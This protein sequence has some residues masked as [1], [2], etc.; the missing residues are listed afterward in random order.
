MDAAMEYVLSQ[1][2]ELVKVAEQGYEYT[3][4]YILQ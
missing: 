1:E 2:W 3:G 4:M